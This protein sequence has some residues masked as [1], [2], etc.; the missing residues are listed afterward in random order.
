MRYRTISI[1]TGLL[2]PLLG[3]TYYDEY[4]VHEIIFHSKFN[5]VQFKFIEIYGDYSHITTITSR[6][7]LIQLCINFHEIGSI[8]SASSII[9][10]ASFL[11]CSKACKYRNNDNRW[12]IYLV[13]PLNLLTRNCI[14]QNLKSRLFQIDTQREPRKL[15]EYLPETFTIT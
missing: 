9:I 4:C 11:C 3:W 14:V 15:R 1:S 8:N 7:P 5:S 6:L 2:L 12:K 13:K 10:T